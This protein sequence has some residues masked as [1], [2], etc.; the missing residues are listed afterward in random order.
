MSSLADA[1]DH[2]SWGLGPSERASVDGLVAGL[3]ADVRAV[4]AGAVLDPER[5]SWARAALAAL[6]LV[7]D[8][9]ATP[10]AFATTAPRR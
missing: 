6:R 5:S 7:V 10:K 2:A 8:R 3:P 4:L 9:G 1:L